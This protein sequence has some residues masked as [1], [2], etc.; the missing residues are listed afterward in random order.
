M[1]EEEAISEL[2]SLMCLSTSIVS[3]GLMVAKLTLPVGLIEAVDAFYYSTLQR[4]PSE[5]KW[6][7][8][9]EEIKQSLTILL[10]YLKNEQAEEFCQLPHPE[11]RSL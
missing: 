11:G 5:D 8:A 2:A 7:L 3:S 9:N 1:S 6:F 4:T 10:G